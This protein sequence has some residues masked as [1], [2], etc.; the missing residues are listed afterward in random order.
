MKFEKILLK[1]TK[2]FF[3]VEGKGK[4]KTKDFIESKELEGKLNIYVYNI[5]FDKLKIPPLKNKIKF[6]LKKKCNG[7]NC[8][9]LPKNSNPSKI[10]ISSFI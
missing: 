5:K 3:N 2:K 4:V 6:K 10:Y 9:K 8:N 7:I 1:G